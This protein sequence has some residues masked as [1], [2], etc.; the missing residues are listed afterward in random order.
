MSKREAIA[1][2]NDELRTTFSSALGCIQWVQSSCYDLDASLRGRALFALTKYSAFEK[3]GYHDAGVFIF[4]GYAFEW[5]IS[6]L[7]KD[8]TGQ[9]PDPADPTKTYRVLAIA[10]TSDVLLAV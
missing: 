4:G 9:S 8:G 10:V 3:K 6:Y 5:D 2:L 1:A 7:G